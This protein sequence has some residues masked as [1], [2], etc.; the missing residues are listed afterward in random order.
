M[1]G[2][3]RIKWALLLEVLRIVPGSWAMLSECQLLS[4]ATLTL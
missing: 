3:A 2:L 1:W 4:L